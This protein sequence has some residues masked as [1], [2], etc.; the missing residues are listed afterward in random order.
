MKA[1]I[2][3]KREVAKGTLLVVFDLLGDE[4]DFKPGQY[5]WVTLARPALRRREGPATPHLGRHLPERPRG[6]RPVHAA[7]RLG[8]QALARRAS[9]GHRGR[10]RTAEGQLR[11]PEDT[12]PPYVFIA[13]GIGITVFR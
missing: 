2:N 8:V 9:R 3:E 7:P 5:F 12:D 6:A 11:A 13:G 1:K 4:V 10:G